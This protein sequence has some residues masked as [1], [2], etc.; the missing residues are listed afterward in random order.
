MCGKAAV[1]EAIP[2]W[3]TYQDY[4]P[5]CLAGDSKIMLCNRKDLEKKYIFTESNTRSYNFS[6]V[7]KLG[8]LVEVNLTRPHIQV[9]I[10]WKVKAYE[11]GMLFSA[12]NFQYL[13]WFSLMGPC[14]VAVFVVWKGYRRLK[15]P[16]ISLHSMD[17]NLCEC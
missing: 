12:R 11:A 2:A 17:R 15:S 10:L 7:F 5:G 8:E 16:Y 1:K 13:S 14:F 6:I 3:S 4:F 9:A